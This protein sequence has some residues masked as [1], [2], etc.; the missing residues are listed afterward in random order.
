MSA[1]LGTFNNGSSSI[2]AGTNSTTPLTINSTAG[3]QFCNSNGTQLGTA[4]SV[5]NISSTGVF[6]CSGLTI[7]GPLTC[8]SLIIPNNGTITCLGSLTCNNTLNMNNNAITGVA[9]LEYSGTISPMYSS[10]SYSSAS[11]IGYSYTSSTS[12]YGTAKTASGTYNAWKTTSLPAGVWMLNYC[13]RLGCV[14]GGFV[15]VGSFGTSLNNVNNSL[16]LYGFSKIWYGMAPVNGT[17]SIS[18]I[19]QYNY[20]GGMFPAFSGSYV[21][22]ATTAQTYYANVDI[23]FYGSIGSGGVALWDGYIQ[24]TRLA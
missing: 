10:P 21:W 2:V 7:S 14:S 11:Q 9:S 1:T 4:S 19:S 3:I 24:A 12:E 23:I 6:N 20:N 17:N 15:N 13:I 16:A 5:C 18:H 8:S 22:T